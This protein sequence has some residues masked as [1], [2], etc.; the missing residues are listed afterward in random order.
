MVGIRV[1][2]DREVSEADATS[3][4][5]REQAVADPGFWAG[6]VRTAPGRPSEWHH[7]AD[8]ETYFYVVT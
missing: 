3:G 8:Y 1:F 7:H 2:R 5:I 6:L 4:M